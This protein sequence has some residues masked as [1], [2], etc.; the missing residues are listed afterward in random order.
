[1][2]LIMGNHSNPQTDPTLKGA[3]DIEVTL[4]RDVIKAIGLIQKQIFVKIGAV[5]KECCILSA[6]LMNAKIIARLE[7]ILS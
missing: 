7:L 3:G 6:S 2:L 4:N 5:K 1:M